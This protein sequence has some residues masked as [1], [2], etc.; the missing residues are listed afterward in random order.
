MQ[1]AFA[2]FFFSGFETGLDGLV[3]TFSD[4]LRRMVAE[5]IASDLLNL[6]KGVLTGGGGGGGGGFFGFVGSLFGRQIGGP[7]KAGQ[8]VRVG[9]SGPEVFTPGA[10]G[11]VRPLGAINFAPVTNINA[12]SGLDIERLI[13]ILDENNRKVK[14]EFVDELRRGKFA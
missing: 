9:E 3:S 13:P 7:V 6:I 2:D 5:L 14:G 10:S 8:P 12:G 11:A 4:T 1:D